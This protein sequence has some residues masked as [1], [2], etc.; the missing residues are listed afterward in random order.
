MTR[1][2]VVCGV[3][4]FGV[5]SPLPIAESVALVGP[6]FSETE[7]DR[8]AI[9]IIRPILLDMLANDRRV[10]YAVGLFHGNEKSRRGLRVVRVGGAMPL[11]S[12]AGARTCPPIET[13]ART[14]AGMMFAEILNLSTRDH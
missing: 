5:Y 10:C 9:K 7:N 1:Q 3:L 2:R 8:K 13:M 14:I 6:T 12:Y 4:R 11:Q